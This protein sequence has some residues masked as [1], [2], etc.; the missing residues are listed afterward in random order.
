MYTYIYIFLICICIHIYLYLQLYVYTHLYIH[1]CKC[2]PKIC[3]ITVCTRPT[4]SCVC[5]FCFKAFSFLLSISLVLCS[6]KHSYCRRSRARV[7]CLFCFSFFPFLTFFFNLLHRYV[8]ARSLLSNFFYSWSFFARILYRG[9]HGCV[10]D[11][12]PP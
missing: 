5:V 6:C 2:A 10:N 8:I 3:S 7:N 12:F 1:V 4:F 9:A 11:F